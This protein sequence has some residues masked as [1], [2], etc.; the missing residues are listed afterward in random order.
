MRLFFRLILLFVHSKFAFLYIIEE[1]HPFLFLFVFLHYIG[2]LKK[3][4]C[5][6]F[7]VLADSKINDHYI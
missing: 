2:E 5:N 1:T 4:D 6:R 7:H 3:P